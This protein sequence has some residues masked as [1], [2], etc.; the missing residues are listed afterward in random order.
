MSNYIVLVKQVPDVSQIS[1]NAFNPET[2]TLMRNKLASVINELD[3]HALAFASQMRKLENSAGKIIVLTMGPPAAAEVLRYS[4]ARCADEAVLVTDRALGGA[5]TYATANTI[6]AAI[7]RIAKEYFTGSDYYVIAGM[8]SVDGDTA[9]VPPQIAADLNMP[10]IAYATD[11]LLK[12]H[13]FEFTRI[14]SG[15]IETVKPI[16]R[17]ALVTVA[18]YD[19]PLYSS[20]ASTRKA[21]RSPIVQWSLTDIN[22]ASF[23]LQGSKTQVIKVFPPPKSQRKC[24]QLQNIAELA[25]A[26]IDSACSDTIVTPDASQ[27]GRNKATS[28]PKLDLT[29]GQKDFWV[30]A[31][32][33]GQNLTDVTFELIAKARSLASDTAAQVSAVL[34]TTTSDDA[35]A[36]KLIEAGADTVHIISDP[37]LNTDDPAPYAK[38]LA[39]LISQNWPQIVFFGATPF[40]RTLA[41]MVSYSLHCGLTADCTAFDIIPHGDDCI[42]L[43]T[44]PALGGNVMATICSKNCKSQMATARPGVFVK[45]QADPSRTGQIFVHNPGLSIADMSLEIVSSEIGGAT[46]K[47]VNKKVI[48]SGGKGL[49]NRDNYNYITQ[50]LAAAV[51]TALGT[52]AE[53][54]ASRSAVEHGLAPRTSQIGQTGTSVAPKVYIAIGISGAIQHMIGIANSDIIIAINND[55]NAPICKAS[56]YYYAASAEEVVPALAKELEKLR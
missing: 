51:K 22:P 28:I 44:R 34:C 39:K 46:S 8:Q 52:S 32:T 20:F 19:H 11:V 18:K 42:L 55:P 6:A 36:K 21:A 33:M 56:D 27:Q 7:R 23:G 2:G 48:I 54:G 13:Q 38:A 1:D 41:P 16:F 47:F 5:D 15:G 43:Q 4:L 25:K 29:L 40:G 24:I 17:P 3:T 30:V 35:H 31:E 50:L 9:Q 26:I 14:I 45:L 37:L 53:I 49:K 10:C 12:N